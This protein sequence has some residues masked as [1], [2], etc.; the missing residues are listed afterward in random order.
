MPL[1]TKC[2]WRL[3]PSRLN[4]TARSRRAGP[5]AR[6]PPDQLAWQTL[7]RSAREGGGEQLPIIKVEF[8]CIPIVFVTEGN[9]VPIRRFPSWP[10]SNRR[11]RRS[12]YRRNDAPGLKHEGQSSNDATQSVQFLESVPKRTRPE[13]PCSSQVD[14]KRS[15]AVPD[16]NRSEGSRADLV[17]LR[18]G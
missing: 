7:S 3:S 10:P 1:P 14:P 13:G 5:R 16:L 4:R 12:L 2:V 18:V 17:L 8:I 15:S 9:Y 11:K 6:R